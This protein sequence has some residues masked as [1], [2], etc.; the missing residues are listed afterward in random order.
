MIDIIIPHFGA[1]PDLTRL[2]IRCLES[3][4]QHSKNYRVIF[5]DNGT[6]DAEWTIILET[7]RQLP[8][9]LIRN[10]INQGFVKAVNQGISF[11]L[12]G[13]AKYQVLLN[14][15]TEAVPA[16]LEKLQQPFLE[17]PQVGLCG[18]LTTDEGWQGKYAERNP[19]A[20]GWGVLPPGR[21]L[22]FFCTMFS[23]K[24]VETVG[25][26]DEDFVPYG[27]FGGDDLYCAQAEKAGFLL[28]LQRDLVIPHHRRS[29]FK[30]V[31]GADAIPAMQ[32]EALN[33]FYEKRRALKA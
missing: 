13:D 14:N 33:L 11:S 17:E 18:P 3:I 16:W 7:L 31:H 27:G 19:G 1:S 22:A 28:A 4:A 23:R 30:V 32:T 20:T 8:H 24:C 25:L 26:H 15:D 10:R 6:P 21:M 29:T 2:A 5:I 9:V 12:G